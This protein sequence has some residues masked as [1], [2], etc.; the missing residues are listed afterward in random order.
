MEV[1]LKPKAPRQMRKARRSQP[2]LLRSPR[3]PTTTGLSQAP[4]RVSPQQK[5]FWLFSSLLSLLCPS[6][7][8][9]W[10][11]SVRAT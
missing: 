3:N 9:T 4:E 7:P 6:K 5:A 1:A 8:K 11:K 10:K 2:S